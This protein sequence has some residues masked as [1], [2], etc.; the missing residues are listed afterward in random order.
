MA[1]TCS[2]ANREFFEHSYFSVVHC[3]IRSLRKNENL[4]LSFLSRHQFSFGVV[5][6]Y[7]TWL[8]KGEHISFHGYNFLSSCRD[9]SSRGGGVALLIKSYVLYSVRQDVSVIDD[10]SETIFVRLTSGTV[11]GVVYRPPSSSIPSFLDR[12]ENILNVSSFGNKYP[13]L[14]TGDFNID[15]SAGQN[16]DYTLLL[17][18]YSFHNLINMPTRIAKKY[19]YNH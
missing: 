9:T 8:K 18:S 15:T 11:V 17:Q 5:A 12:M 3:N 13:V 4:L 14:I 19:R 10:V 16:A 7:E 1:F 2:Q 6:L